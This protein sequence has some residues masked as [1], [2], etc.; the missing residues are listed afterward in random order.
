MTNSLINI[1]P[2]FKY[3]LCALKIKYKNKFLTYNYL[4]RK[5]W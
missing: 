1:K 2:I 5:N 3:K 4:I